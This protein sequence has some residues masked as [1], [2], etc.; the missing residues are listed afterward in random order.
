MKQ[1]AVKR[2]YNE[3]KGR[4]NEKKKEKMFL[5]RYVNFWLFYVNLKGRKLISKYFNWFWD[6]CVN[7][8]LY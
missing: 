4:E 7:A 3:T 6:M 1:S 5:I 2:Y 8:L